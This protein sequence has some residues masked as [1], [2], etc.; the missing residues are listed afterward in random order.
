MIEAYELTDLT[1]YNIGLG[2]ASTRTK[3]QK[4]KAQEYTNKIMDSINGLML[5]SD[6]SINHRVIN[7]G[8]YGG[9]IAN[10][11]TGEV[12]STWSNNMNTNDAQ[13]TEL[14]GINYALDQL[15]ITSINNKSI[16]I[17]CD[18]KNVVNY[19]NDIYN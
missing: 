4:I 1:M 7:G 11:K 13:F 8:G 2:S 17:L 19:I 5:L 14:Q 16:D 10:I 3:N 9:L 15:R 6:G 12:I 18:C